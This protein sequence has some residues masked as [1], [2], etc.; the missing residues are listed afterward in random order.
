MSPEEL[1]KLKKPP[2]GH[3]SPNTAIYDMIRFWGRKPHNLVRKY[4]ECYTHKGDVVLDPFAGCGVVAVEALKSKRRVIYNDLNAYCRFIGKVSSAPVDIKALNLAF[5]ELLKRI[6]T[7]E[8]PVIAG[9]KKKKINFEWLYS[10]KCEKCTGEAEIIG[11]TYTKVYN[12][13]RIKKSRLRSLKG[14]KGEEIP[15][16]LIKS[17]DTLSKIAFEVYKVIAE[18]SPISHDELTKKL[19]LDVRPEE[20]TRA[21]NEKLQ[22]QGLVEV[23]S[24]TPVS[25]EYICRNTKCSARRI[26]KKPDEDD[27]RK[28]EEINNMK[29]AYYYPKEKLSYPTTSRFLTY[30]PGTESVDRLFTSRNLIALSIL[31]NEI[32]KL[33]ASPNIKQALLLCFAAILEH[34]CKMERPNKKGWGVKNYILHPIFFEQNVLHAF[35]NRFELVAEGKEELGSKIGD[36][37]RESIRPTN[38]I[39]NSDTVCFLNVDSRELPLKDSSIDYV[40][41]DP[42]YGD[43]IQYYELSLMASRWLNLKS[44]WKK[45]I[46]VNPKQG[47]TPEIYRDMLTT[48]FKQVYRVLK[49]SKYMT[50]TF[51][52]REIRY[53]NALMYAIQVA[54]FKY[55]SAIYQV[56]QK[57]YTNWL[58]A[59][60][61]GEMTGDVYITFY[62][63]EV[64]TKP[65]VIDID[66]KD[67]TRD[68]ILPEA[69]EIILLHNGQATFNQLVRGVTLCLISKGLMQSPKIRDLNYEA[70]FDGHF[71]RLGRAKVWR[72]REEERVSP[73]D[74]IP[75]DRRIAWIIFSVFN[76]IH[77]RLRQKVTVTD[78]LSAIFTTLKNAKTPEN[79]EIMDIL[80]DVAEPMKGKALPYWEPRKEIQTTLEFISA[81]PAVPKEE[82]GEK[83]D[84]ERV[85][86]VISQLGADFGF[87]V[88]IGDPEVR[89]NAELKKYR[90]VEELKI[91]AVDKVVLDRLKN[92]DVVWLRRKTMPVCLI[93]VEHTTDLRGGLVR[94]ANI[95]EVA[96]H[97]DVKTFTI[98]P[99]KRVLKL[100]E[101]LSEPTIKHLVGEKTIYYATY[102]LIAQLSDETEYRKLRF[103]DFLSICEVLEPTGELAPS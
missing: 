58:Y 10:T 30:R 36:F 16:V 103:K 82:V 11:V 50:V 98:I 93:E 73:V 49:P 7:E 34:V 13:A 38:V 92:V 31:R 54:G 72:L 67:V 87:D 39:E 20:I 15:I 4:I 51:H 40:F 18:E 76:R 3:A 22:G 64:K 56:P 95:F 8:F 9:K 57:E 5:D 23:S 24:E 26:S 61:P 77:Y 45:E 62:K 79:K 70:I 101:V 2:T 96:P 19:K 46:V 32:S 21:I 6:K 47:K 1:S 86:R 65:G 59:R 41:T 68:I 35:R 80:N 78:I 12:R 74:F 88:W 27:L 69:R 25:I 89:K 85:I 29:P 44:D 42:E 90:T 81:R 100:K 66:L 48:A 60:N 37:Y 71:K 75:L 55:V 43:S 84:H 14:V 97:L 53:W 33:D 83:Y 52:S 91:A 94:M 63:P 28:I 102:S 17:K 99:D